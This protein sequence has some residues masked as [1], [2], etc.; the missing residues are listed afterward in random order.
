MFAITMEGGQNS[1]LPDVCKTPTPGGPVPMP[2]PNISMPA[3]VDPP[4]CT[5]KVFID[6]ML[7][8][9]LNS[10]IPM[11][12]GDEPG[13]AGGVVSNANMGPTTYLM[14][15]LKVY[16]EGHPAV[17]MTSQTK[18]NGSNANTVGAAL[19]P[20]QSKVMILS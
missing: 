19:A 8:L 15:S 13:T 4:T 6:M 5:R 11:S 1:A 20:S 10:T 16:F 2:Y 17:R 18:Q 9:T 12:Q 3:T 14:G 7:V